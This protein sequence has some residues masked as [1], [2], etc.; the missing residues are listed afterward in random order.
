[1]LPIDLISDNRSSLSMGKVAFWITM[2]MSLAYWALGKDTPPTLN[3]AM[4]YVLVYTF[5]QSMVDTK[6]AKTEG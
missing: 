5:G 6:A 3:N 2:L 1:M 4:M